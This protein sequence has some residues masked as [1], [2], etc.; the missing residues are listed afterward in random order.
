[1]KHLFLLLSLIL[2]LPVFAKED[3]ILLDKTPANTAIPAD[4]VALRFNETLDRVEAKNGDGTIT[5]FAA[6]SLTEATPVNGVKAT[7]TLDPTGANNSVL[8]TAVGAGTRYNTIS[9]RYVISGSGSAVLSITT[10]SSVITVT[11]GS[12]TTAQSVI[13]AVTAD[14]TASTYVTAVASGTVSG[15]IAAIGPSALSGGINCTP[16]KKGELRFDGNTLYVAT[17]AM[18]ITST[19]G[20]KRLVLVAL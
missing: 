7:L 11:A 5:P 2:A 4:S 1:M 3:S 14:A 13:T 20:W 18:T 10:A 9:V 16:A 15:T 8:Y 12:A 17:T 19:S 6:P